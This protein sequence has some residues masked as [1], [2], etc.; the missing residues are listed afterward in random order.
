MQ[1]ALAD[2]ERRQLAAKIDEL[3]RAAEAV[4]LGGVATHFPNTTL[5]WD[6]PNLKFK[7]CPDAA[8]YLRR[9][10]RKGWEVRGLS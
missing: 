9:T 4:L 7:N 2:A 10:Y 6:A 8:R 5:E 1:A 3:A